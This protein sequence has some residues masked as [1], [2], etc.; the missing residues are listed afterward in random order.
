MPLA[1]SRAK[2][3]HSPRPMPEAPPVT[4]ATFPSNERNVLSVEWV[5]PAGD[6]LRLGSANNPNAGWFCGDGP[7]PSLRGM[8]KG[9]QETEETT[10]VEKEPLYG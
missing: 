1:P 3:W 2:R 10:D 7:G 4:S 8:M 6:I 9:L 5:T